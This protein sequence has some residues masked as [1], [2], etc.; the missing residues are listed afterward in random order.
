MQGIEQFQQQLRAVP[1]EYLMK[2]M[3][4]PSGNVPQFLIMAELQRRKKLR[5][6]AQAE[7]ADAMPATVAEDTLNGVAQLPAENMVNMRDGGIV[8]FADGG[9]TEREKSPLTET[10]EEAERRGQLERDREFV[11]GIW[12]FIQRGSAASADALAFPTRWM[13]NQ[14][15]GAAGDTLNRAGRVGNLIVGEPRFQTN[16]DW[17]PF[18]YWGFSNWVKGGEESGEAAVLPEF[19]QQDPS[20]ITIMDQPPEETGVAALAPTATRTE[21]DAE[22]IR[23]LKLYG[24]AR[25]AGGAGVRYGGGVRAPALSGLGVSIPDVDRSLYTRPVESPEAILAQQKAVRGKAGVT[26]EF[27]ADL[28]KYLRDRTKSPEEA[29]AQ[30]V[31]EALMTAGIAM[32]AGESPYFFT[33]VGQGLGAGMGQYLK[34]RKEQEAEDFERMKALAGIEEKRRGEK[35]T[36]ADAALQRSLGMSDEN[37]KGLQRA[38]EQQRLTDVEKMKAATDLARTQM[39]VNGTLRAAQIRASGA[40]DDARRLEMHQAMAAANNEI[41]DI[42]AKYKDPSKLVLMFNGKVDSATVAA[43]KSAELEDVNRR[44]LQKL[45]MFDNRQLATAFSPQV[46]S[47]L[48]ELRPQVVEGM[49]TGIGGLGGAPRLVTNPAIA[50]QATPLR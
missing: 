17:R 36:S 35:I 47:R 40:Q 33:N 14:L 18:D 20:R 34:A 41:R 37:F 13:W 50:K 5:A 1:D 25:D 29:K 22:I 15:T 39:Q 23:R 9:S 16:R 42:H 46:V 45:T 8:R 2:E 24:P 44:L 19:A 49:F 4:Q 32:M 26:G 10:L 21:T 11:G 3:Q 30:N 12:P 27:G 7:Q 48:D 28:E 31:K 38:G 6:A 43:T